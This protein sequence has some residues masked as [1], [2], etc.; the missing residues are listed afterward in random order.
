MKT[1][2]YPSG[3]LL[4]C[5]LMV[6]LLSG[7]LKK[8]VYNPDQD[9]NRSVFDF[10]TKSSYTLNVQYDVTEGHRIYFEVYTESP[11]N[12][13]G[14]KKEGLEAIDKGYTDE[15]GL[16]SKP[17]YMQSA[18]KKVYI[19]TPS[20]GVPKVMEAE[21]SNGILQ[22]AKVP[23]RSTATQSKSGIATR[24]IG[25][26]SDVN[27]NNIET[28]V[29]G[30]WSFSDGGYSYVPNAGIWKDQAKLWGRPD[31]LK[32]VSQ[33]SFPGVGEPALVL[34]STIEN[35]IDAVLPGDGMGLVSEE[36]LK[37]GDIH[38]SKDAEI[39]LYFIEDQCLYM[40]TLAY[41]CYETNNPPQRAADIKVQTIAFPSAKEIKSRMAYY[42][43]TVEMDY[44]A[45][46]RGEGIRLHYFDKNGDDKGTVFPAGTSIGW[47]LYADGFNVRGMLGMGGGAVS[48][49]KGARYSSK[50]LNGGIPYT[51]VFRHKDFVITSFE[52]G[53]NGIDIAKSDFKDLIFHVASSPSDAI[54]PGIPDVDPEN[55]DDDKV[56]MTV[57]NRGILTFEDQWP[58]QGDF[59]MNDVVVK[60][61]STV[62]Y[63]KKN[64]V[65]ETTDDFTIL[66]AG[67]TYNNNFAY[68]N[69][70]LATGKAE[71]TITTSGEQPV[72]DKANS[73]V[74][75][76]NRV[77]DYANNDQKM[78]YS[79]KTT[80]GQRIDKANY[81]PAPYNPFIAVAGDP[82]REV[83]LSNFTPTSYANPELLG[84]AH[85]CSVPSANKYYITYNKSGIQMPFAIDITFTNNAEMDCFVIPEESQNISIYYPTFLNW[86]K[87]GGQED[88]DWFL[89]PKK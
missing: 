61:I 4:I 3:K 67:A 41:Y 19:Y 86:I 27:F 87:T 47:I 88:R 24:T 32:Y 58:Y 10:S 31:Y 54:T 52:D 63:N 43:G 74:R 62:G 33:A 40:N 56:A 89:K 12:E 69:K 65:V 17:L 55:P 83:H 15:N 18:V 79:V 46:L 16:Y 53:G 6:G 9:K 1:T 44:G 42:P 76:A 64:E 21:V 59:D 82:G 28:R 22:A 13:E 39:D 7:C 38:V 80:Y 26:V 72:I 29:L 11:L 50:E 78:T 23:A 81:I 35:T 45:L 20:V 49:G 8:D 36:V 66:G 85:D 25:N 75:L 68:E 71:V 37:N 14:K 2:K 73:I 34:P 5:F 84:S 57:T 77:L 48:V 30:S 60:Y 70:N 51:A